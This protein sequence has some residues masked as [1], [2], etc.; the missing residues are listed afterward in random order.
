M[1]T[2]DF[3]I[4]AVRM[5]LEINKKFLQTGLKN[6]GIYLICRKARSSVD[7]EHD[8]GLS[9]SCVLYFCPVWHVSIILR[10]GFSLAI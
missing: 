10:A 5:V 7:M 6:E 9:F 4:H 8:Q 2:F 3:H 1:I